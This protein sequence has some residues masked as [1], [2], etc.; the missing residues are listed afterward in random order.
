MDLGFKSQGVDIIWANDNYQYAAETY[1][2]NF[3]IRPILDDIRSIEAF[4]DAD[5]V[6]ACNPCQGFSMIGARK[7]HDKR[8]MLYKEIFRCVKQVKPK[9]LIMENVLGLKQ[10]YRGKYLFRILKGLRQLGYKV[11]WKVLDAKHYGVPQHRER[12]IIVGIRSDLKYEYEFPIK[13]HGP[14]LIPY[15]TLREAIGDL[16]QPKEGEYFTSHRWPFFYMSRN[17]RANWDSVS[18]TIQTDTYSI[19]L[20]P[21]SPPMKKLEK[22]KFVFTGNLYNYRRLSVAECSR[23]QTFPDEFQFLGFLGS[24]YRLIGNAVPPLLAKK[25]A[26]SIIAMESC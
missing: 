6:I 24:Q 12:I 15:V 19:P 4:P 5:L 25:I 23:I 13:T 14:E 8:N 2:K 11:K 17:R 20:H 10:L 26:K 21:S 3:G 16:P 18:Y 7:E 9:F 22:D 1:E